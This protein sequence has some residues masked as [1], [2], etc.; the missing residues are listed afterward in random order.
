MPG[1]CCCVSLWV[2]MQPPCNSSHSQNLGLVTLLSLPPRT[3]PRDPRLLSSFPLR[4]PS[5]V[6]AFPL[7]ESEAV[8]SWGSL[9]DGRKLTSQGPLFSCF[10]SGPWQQFRARK[11]SSFLGSTSSLWP[12]GETTRSAG[13]SGGRE[14]GDGQARR[15]V[16]GWPG[17]ERENMAKDLSLKSRSAVPLGCEHPKMVQVVRSSEIATARH[18]WFSSSSIICR[19][20]ALQRKA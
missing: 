18:P 12:P 9:T 3:H 15:V 11:K 14:K 2:S 8:C 4:A 16:T 17:S 13:L 1:G 5:P 10:S 6:L 19:K 20:P 7:L